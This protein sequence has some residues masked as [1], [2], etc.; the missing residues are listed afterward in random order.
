M[1]DE[2]YGT[3]L[4]W[5]YPRAGYAPVYD[6]P[7]A[8]AAVVG[9]LGLHFVRRLRFEG[10]IGATAP[11]RSLWAQVVTPAGQVGYV[12]PGTLMSLASEQLCYGKDAVG[13][14]RITGFIAGTN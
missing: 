12:A 1:L 6:A 3:G 13:R 9:T 11:S 4:D 10:S 5:T 7:H 14:W 2:T 8:N